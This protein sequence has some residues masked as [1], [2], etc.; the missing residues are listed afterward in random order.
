MERTR[1]SA[2]NGSTAGRADLVSFQAFYDFA[3]ERV[4]RFSLRRVGDVARAEALTE[5][6]LDSALTS[7]GGVHAADESLRGDPAELAFRLFAIAV[8]VADEIA[9]DPSRLDVP[10]VRLGATR[11]SLPVRVPPNGSGPAPRRRLD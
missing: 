7:L 1:G 3:F 11:P 10:V 5:R 2:G 4:H 8:R 9:E 6:I